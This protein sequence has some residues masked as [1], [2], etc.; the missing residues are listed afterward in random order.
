MTRS[1]TSRTDASRPINSDTGSGRLDTGADLT[2]ELIATSRHRANQT[3]VDAERLAKRGD[4]GLE[5]VLFDDP[6]WP[7]PAHQLVLVEDCAAGVDQDEQ[8]VEGATTERDGCA[9]DNELAAMGHHL[10]DSLIFEVGAY[11]MTDAAKIRETTDKTRD[12][13]MK[14]GETSQADPPTGACDAP[15]LRR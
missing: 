12:D 1:R 9:V 8:R 10:D 11:A 6:V 7:D 2:G 3:A 13:L 15:S 4:L 5:V 14:V